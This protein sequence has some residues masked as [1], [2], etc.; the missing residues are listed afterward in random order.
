MGMVMESSED[1]LP[2]FESGVAAT[3]VQ[4][5]KRIRWFFYVE[6]RSFNC[7]NR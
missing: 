6:A 5:D 1:T 4:D 7:P 3:A 2:R